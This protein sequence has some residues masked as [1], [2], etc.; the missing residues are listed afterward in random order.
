MCVANSARSQI[1]EGLARKTL[2]DLA[3]VQS[4]GS[5]PKFVHPLAKQVLLEAGIDISDHSSKLFSELPPSFVSNLTCLIT[6]CAEEVC[7]VTAG[8]FQRRAWPFPDPAD[9]SKSETEQLAS[10]REVRDRI[11][12][13]IEEFRDELLRESARVT[14]L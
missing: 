9:A 10:F 6:L 11:Q 4:A 1:A 14:S 3:E 12:L 8:H 7:P 5:S 13:K 2:G